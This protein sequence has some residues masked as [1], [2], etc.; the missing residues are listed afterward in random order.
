VFTDHSISLTFIRA[1]KPSSSAATRSSSTVS[2]TIS[3]W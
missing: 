2:I 3:G 1:A